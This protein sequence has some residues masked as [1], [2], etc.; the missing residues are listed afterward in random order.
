MAADMQRTTKMQVPRHRRSTIRCKFASIN[1]KSA[2]DHTG[3]AEGLNVRGRAAQLRTE[4]T[5][6][7]LA[8]IMMQETRTSGPA[9]RHNDDYFIFASGRSEGTG[10]PYGCEIWIAREMKDEQGKCCSMHQHS[11]RPVLQEPRA[12]MVSVTSAAITADVVS[13]HAPCRNQDYAAVEKYWLEISEKITT[14]RRPGTPLIIGVDA[15]H[16]PAPNDVGV[17][18]LA[19][20]NVVDHPFDTFIQTFDLYVPHTWR[21][22]NKRES[23][24]PTFYPHSGM[25]TAIDYLLT[26]MEWNEHYM[27]ADTGEE[28]DV[29]MS[30][31]D[32]L[33]CTLSVD[34]PPKPV[35]IH[36]TNR[37]IGY[38]TEAL[39]DPK[40]ADKMERIWRNAP[41][42]PWRVEPTT[43]WFRLSTYMREALTRQFPKKKGRP[44]PPWMSRATL[45]LLEAKKRSYADLLHAKKNNTPGI[46]EAH[47]RHKENVK[48][49]RKQVMVDRRDTLEQLQKE[50]GSAFEAAN[51]KKAYQIIRSMRPYAPRPTNYMKDKDG[52]VCKDAAEA[53]EAWTDHWAQKYGGRAA[54]FLELI[55][56]HAAGWERCDYDN[57]GLLATPTPDE[58]AATAVAAASKSHGPDLI[59]INAIKGAPA[60]AAARIHPVAMKCCAYGW[61]PFLWCGDNRAALPKASRPS[62]N[63]NDMRGIALQ[64][65]APKLL[66]KHA[67]AALASQTDRNMPETVCGA[68]K[69]K[70]TEFAIH[71]QTAFCSRAKI[72]DR[73]AAI[74]FLDLSAAFDT[75][76]RAALATLPQGQAARVIQAA[77]EF[78]WLCPPTSD[79]P[80]RTVNG[81]NQ[82]DPASD[83][84]FVLVL[85]RAINELYDYLLG[86]DLVVYILGSNP[87]GPLDLTGDRSNSEAILN[88]TSFIDDMAIFIETTIAGQL[89]GAIDMVASNAASILRRHGFRPNFANGKTEATYVIRGQNARRVKAD[90]FEMGYVLKTQ[91]GDELR[92]VNSYKHL[93]TQHAFTAAA[94]K[95]AKQA[96]DV[97]HSISTTIAKP[98][99]ANKHLDIKHK[100]LLVE[101]TLAKALYA[102]A[103]WPDLTACQHQRIE[104]AYNGLIRHAADQHWKGRRKP[105]RNAELEKLGFH[106]LTTQ[107]R[108]RRLLYLGRLTNKGPRVL[109]KMLLTNYAEDRKGTTWLARCIQDLSWIKKI[110]RKLE[111]LPEPTA[112]LEQWHALIAGYPAAWR[113]IVKLAHCEVRGTAEDWQAAADKEEDDNM[114]ACAACGIFYKGRQG[115]NLHLH[116]AHGRRAPARRYAN[117]EHTCKV[118]N[119]T[120]PHRSRLIQHLSEGYSRRDAGSC[121][122][123]LAI[124]AAPTVAEEEAQRLDEEERQRKTNNRKKG[125]HPDAADRPTVAASEPEWESKLGCAPKWL[126]RF[127]LFAPE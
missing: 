87:E 39:K 52:R 66:H 124:H 121:L 60:A 2:M 41:A 44:K 99:M 14:R 81:V 18:C 90:F 101:V 89:L 57:D 69:G 26:P 33:A 8:I 17:G 94:S 93:G 1:V 79:R 111:E 59:H 122:G 72:T 107:M 28:I 78:T 98:M 30:C 54:T 83:L 13:L 70:N 34:L 37:D 11:I 12:L 104:N 100:R 109:W 97:F 73:S 65:A 75:V 126:S 123:Q 64:S 119:R 45:A 86:E 61:R 27:E 4:F 40:N 80:V 77:H 31:I 20:G 71:L 106:S 114:F 68:V 74:L 36:K 29:S 53:G 23:L 10:K 127:E 76:P 62:G 22:H 120:F 115:L 15:N 63:P 47:W 48:K 42:V 102:V 117:S 9:T 43:H 5:K 67:R 118:C 51:L 116:K 82:G 88:G 108:T 49:L 110:S 32:H 85:Q 96:I 103:V 3:T 58:L 46:P 25:P 19:T 55:E 35:T 95:V 21:K 105:C 92:L 16:E 56:E 38:D 91:A 6:A 50:V 112:S 24:Q 113:Q 84:A 7:G 125:L